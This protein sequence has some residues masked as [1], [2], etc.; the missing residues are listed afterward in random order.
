MFKLGLKWHI[1]ELDDLGLKRGVYRLIYEGLNRSGA[2]RLLHPIRR[3][4]TIKVSHYLGPEMMDRERFRQN[5]L[6]FFVRDGRGLKD[7]IAAIIG[8]EGVEKLLAMG[9]AAIKGRIRCFSAWEG[10]YGQPVDWHLNPRRHVSWPREVHWSKASAFEPIG[11]DCKLVWELNRFPHLYTWV[12]AYALT[13][14][15][16]WVRAFCDQLKSWEEANPYRGGINWNSGQELAI[17]AM[18]WVLALYV[19]VDDAAFED[20]DFARLMRLLY[21]HGEHLLANINFAR[22]AVYNNHLIGEAL[23]LYLLGSYFPWM[24]GAHRW[25]GLGRRLLEGECLG[26]FYADGGY[27]QSSHNYHRLALHYYLWALRIGECLGEPF[28]RQIYDMLAKSALYL[29]SFMNEADGRLPNWGANDGALLCPWTNCDYSDFRPILNSIRY[30]TTGKRAFEPGPWDEELLWLWG[31]GALEAEIDPYPRPQEA[32]YKESGLYL[33][34]EGPGDFAVFRCG[35]LRDRF[36][37]ADQLHVDIW[38]RGLNIAQDGGSY[39]YNDELSYH[40]YFMGTSSHN[41]VA[42]DGQDQMQLIRRFK[43]LNLVQA[44]RIETGIPPGPGKWYVAGEHYGYRRLKG[45]LVHRRR[46]MAL[47]AGAYLVLDNLYP[48]ARGKPGQDKSVHQQVYRHKFQLHWL[49]G[50][51]PWE[52]CGAGCLPCG[53]KLSTPQGPF[54]IMVGAFNKAPSYANE[55]SPT[56]QPLPGRFAVYRGL[57]AGTA[58]ANGPR[59]WVSRYYGLRVPA[60]SLSLSVEAEASIVFISL[61][62]PAQAAP[63]V[64]LHGPQICLAT[65]AGVT[66][67]SLWEDSH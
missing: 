11:G 47:G 27:C 14:D 35:S 15:S 33:Y 60:L 12:R 34:R 53:V 10:D 1:Q 32:A 17:R 9:D 49:L 20:E 22:L 64:T 2:R 62:A 37:Q 3:Y 25:K 18:A 65:T 31:P 41:T 45:G 56:W 7:G 38:W 46:V 16:K 39:L 43:W 6:A 48:C 5:R 67:F 36:G 61:L 21:L 66:A 59:G 40:Y 28:P 24:K 23:G 63:E 26:Q 19:F 8:P 55:G 4:T 29:A 42:V 13:G 52:E 50:D 51:W 54:V 58:D 57:E 30:L 44:G